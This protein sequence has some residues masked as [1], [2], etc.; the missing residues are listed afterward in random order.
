M[1]LK[2][3][4]VVAGMA[5]IANMGFSQAAE[6]NNVATEV[7][8]VSNQEISYPVTIEYDIEDNIISIYVNGVQL[9]QVEHFIFNNQVIDDFVHDGREN[10]NITIGEEESAFMMLMSLSLV[11][12]VNKG[13]FG[14]TMSNGTTVFSEIPSELLNGGSQEGS[15]STRK[16]QKCHAKFEI[17][18]KTTN[19]IYLGEVGGFLA[20]KK[21][22]CL[23]KA[24][25]YARNQ[26][27]FSY[28]GFTGQG[29]CEKYGANGVKVEIN[30]EVEGKSNSKDG[31]VSSRLRATC[32]C[33]GYNFVNK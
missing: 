3:L 20:S 16:W 27:H 22:I 8:T 4:G 14:I 12:N 2:T 33:S 1:K 10:G 13:V 11:Q 18:N 6:L 5:L 9:D 32:Q 26:L 29:F 25:S 31:T 28:F 21:R 30:T 24:Y 15:R 17:D 19:W 23:S 7:P